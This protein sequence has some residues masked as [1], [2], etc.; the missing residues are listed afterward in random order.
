MAIIASPALRRQKMLRWFMW[1]TAILII[2]LLAAYLVATNSTV[3]KKFVLPQVSKALNA[4]VTAS[5]I[6]F[7]PFSEITIRNL[8]VT[9]KGEQPL[10]T[11][12][13]LR[14][15]YRFFDIVRGN[16]NVDE[17]QLRTPVIHIIEKP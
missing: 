3:L 14:A 16:I 17:I 7:F 2:L 11:A 6:S 1:L 5:D 8:K 10:L 12:T 13:E 15:R 4:E 9:P